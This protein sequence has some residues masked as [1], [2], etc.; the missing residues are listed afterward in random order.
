MES[1]VSELVFVLEMIGTIAFTI[2]GALTGIRKRMDLLGV[3]ILG[4]VTAVGGGIMRDILLGI[5]PPKA[6]LDGTYLAVS[7]LSSTIIFFYIYL[8]LKGYRHL[9]ETKFTHVVTI[10]DAIGLGI[11][12]VVGVKSVFDAG[13]AYNLFIPV[14]LGAM[15]GVGGGLLRDILAGDR[16][17]IFVKHI[18]AC[19]SIAGAILCALLW[20]PAG[21]AVSMLSGFLLVVLVRFIAIRYKLNLPHIN[22]MER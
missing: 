10:A 14:F 22:D 7:V 15:T 4:V 8:R 16:P 9:S 18:Y 1:A 17:Y 2:S 12:S 21:E 11:F 20:K 19:A 3:I 5:F 13:F 6:F